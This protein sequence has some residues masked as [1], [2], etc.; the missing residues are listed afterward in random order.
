[1]KKIYNIIIL[2]AG[3][4]ITSC[5]ESPIGQTPTDATPPGAL[6]NV[7][8]EPLP[9]GAKISYDFP[10]ETDISYVKGEY[11]FQDQIKVARASVY[12]NF[13]IIEGLNS[14]APVN[15]T[16]TL[17]DHSE[18][19]SVPVTTT[20]TPLL[21]PFESIYE[22]VVISEDWGGCTITWDNPTGAEVGLIMYAADSTG[23]LEQVDV[24]FTPAK[25]G[26][27]SLRGYPAVERKFGVQITDKWENSSKIKEKTLLPIFEKRL[28]RTKH[29]QYV[30]PYD[31]TSS[32]GG[33]Q[34]FTHMFDGNGTGTGNISW[35][36]QE[37]Q[38]ATSMGFTHP[39]MF[40]VNLGVDAILNRFRMWQ[41]RWADYFLY[42]HHNPRTFEVWGAM[43]I[44]TDKPNAYWLEDWKQD[45]TLLGDLEIIKPS[46]APSGDVLAEDRAAA[47]AGHEFYL[48]TVPVRYLRFSVKS[49]W[50]GD[51]DNT[52]TIHELAF[53]GNDGTNDETN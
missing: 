24:Y 33:N 27:Y 51:K 26:S 32:N 18:N 3:L 23:V 34:I 21:P 14:V 38:A 44:P 20:I 43:S 35:H 37:N 36:T 5:N 41:G 47:D 11:L 19:A 49:T 48:T 12:D 4:L 22:S 45:W 16:L 29:S 7:Q 8:S 15:V 9:G 42:G 40:T 10:K 30:L 31:N 13:L 17:I 2:L 28:D 25:V 1:M 46:G 53:W 6:L 52:I 39:V 50:I